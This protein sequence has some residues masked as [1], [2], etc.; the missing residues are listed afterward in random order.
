MKSIRKNTNSD[1]ESKPRRNNTL[2]QKRQMQIIKKATKL[3]IKKGYAQ[4]SMR[5]IS[6]AT[7]IDIR[8][9]YYFIKSKDE[10]LFLVCQMI[11][12][13]MLEIVR[14]QNILDMDDPV[15][16]LSAVIRQLI[17]FGYDYGQEILLMYRESK[18]LSKPLRKIIFNQESLLVSRIEEILIRGKERNVFQFEDASFTA[19]FLVYALSLRPLRKWNMQNYTKDELLNLLVKNL[20]GTV[21]A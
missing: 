12:T 9:L 19:N 15:E 2:Y 11:H 5:E 14:S 10:I 6:K 4:T 7:G 17:D 18:S 16:Q 3:F 1:S 20:M 21:L 13:P 8:N